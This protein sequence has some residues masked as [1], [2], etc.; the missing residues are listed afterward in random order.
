MD[1]YEL[2]EAFAAVSLSVNKELK[3]DESKINIHGGAIALGKYRQI[4]S[5]NALSFTFPNFYSLQAIQLVLLAV[6]F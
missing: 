4:E 5:V 3:I 2:N 1:L 6:V